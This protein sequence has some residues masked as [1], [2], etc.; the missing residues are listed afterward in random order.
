MKK[1]SK[2]DDVIVMDDGWKAQIRKATE[3][4]KKAASKVKAGTSVTD[5][6]KKKAAIDAAIKGIKFEDKKKK[7]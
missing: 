1:N 2:I 3:T 6:K 4:S 7:K 5:P